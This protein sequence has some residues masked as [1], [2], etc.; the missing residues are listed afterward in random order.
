[1]DWYFGSNRC[2]ATLFPLRNIIASVTEYRMVGISAHCALSFV[3][4][5]SNVFLNQIPGYAPAFIVGTY[6]R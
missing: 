5:F 2:V 1:M 3:N 6:M 4:L